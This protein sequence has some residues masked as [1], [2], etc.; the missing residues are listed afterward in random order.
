MK[1]KVIGQN[2]HYRLLMQSKVKVKLGKNRLQGDVG[3][4]DVNVTVRIA[5]YQ[6]LYLSL[7]VGV[8]SADGFLL[9]DSLSRLLY[10]HMQLRMT[11]GVV[12]LCC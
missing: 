7:V 9:F 5:L 6:V 3:N 10:L 8:T 4:T 1:V 11:V 12:F 2:S